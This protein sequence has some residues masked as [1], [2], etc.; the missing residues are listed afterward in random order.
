MLWSPARH[1]GHAMQL[2][3]FQPKP[4]GC[5]RLTSFALR[6][7]ADTV[8][9]ASCPGTRGNRLS[10]HSLWSMEKSEWQI[11]QYC[12]SISTCSSPSGPG[13][14]VKGCSFAP[15]AEAANA[16]ISDIRLGCGSD[17]HD[18]LV[19]FDM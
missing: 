4:T 1:C 7:T 8:P 5:P 17:G 13:S 19:N 16:R 12:T 6:P 11:P 18:S 15:A 3:E 14:Y 2:P 10:C 9:M